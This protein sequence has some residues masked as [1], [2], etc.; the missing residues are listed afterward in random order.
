MLWL[1]ALLNAGL[2]VS[3][4]CFHITEVQLFVD[5][6]TFGRQCLTQCPRVESLDMQSLLDLD[7]LVASGRSAQ[8][9][10]DV[11]LWPLALSFCVVAS[12]LVECRLVVYG[13]Y[14]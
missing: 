12:G 14:L 2:V 8:A 4:M 6:L 5:G 7:Y 3:G 13:M 11:S 9:P 1:Q 10:D